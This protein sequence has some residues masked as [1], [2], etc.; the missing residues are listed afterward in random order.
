MGILDRFE[1]RLDRMV[2]S[3]FARAFKSE[4]Q[5]VE[6]ASALQREC[7]DRAAIVGRDRTIV[8]NSFSVD[9]APSDF[10]R[11][12]VYRDALSR[13]HADLVREP[14]REQGYAFVGPLAVDIKRDDELET[15]L[16]RVLGE[17]APGDVPV[18]LHLPRAWLD[19]AGQQVP[20]TQDVS[21]IGRGTEADVVVADPGT[22][23]RHAMLRLR[24]TPSIVDL[25]STNGTLVDDIR[26]EQ[27]DL[28]DGSVITLGSTRIVFRTKET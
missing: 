22:S 14:A 11:L 23:R 7:D 24:P 21:I 15:G 6:I 5:P 4:V 16:F 17:A 2:N 27:S 3:A 1:R 13:E 26:A 18:D 9:L 8:P 25:G 12:T 20:L 10:D 28:S 19:V